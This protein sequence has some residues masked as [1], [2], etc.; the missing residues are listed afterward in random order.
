MSAKRAHFEALAPRW[1]SFRPS[2]A[3]A[4]ASCT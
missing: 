3:A 1:E 4:V 2:G